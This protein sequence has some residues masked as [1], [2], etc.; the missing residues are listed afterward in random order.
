M[1]KVYIIHGWEG[2]PEEPMHKWLKLKLEEAGYEVTVPEMPEAENPKIEAWVG[3]LKEIIEPGPDTILVGH[4]IGCQGILR[5]IETLSEGSKIAGLVLIA[6][7]MKLDMKTIEEEGEEVIEMAKPWMETP[8]DFK[9][10]KTHVGGMVAIFSDND[11]YVPLDQQE[12]FKTELGAEIIVEK[13]KGHFTEGD[14]VEDLPSALE[15]VKNIS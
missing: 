14:G 1:K 4:S 10:V 5:Y 2:S 15:A 7:W 3:K 13:Q 11:P 12:L 8:I 6:P 9:K